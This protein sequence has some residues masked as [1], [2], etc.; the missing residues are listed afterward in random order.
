MTTTSF[1][2]IGTITGRMSGDHRPNMQNIPRSMESKILHCL[3]SHGMRTFDQ[4]ALAAGM[5]GPDG[6]D[7]PEK[8]H[9]TVDKKLRELMAC[10]KIRLVA[11]KPTLCFEVGT[12]LDRIVKEIELDGQD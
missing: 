2:H 9:D 8:F 5:L 12:V 7:N 4:L 6:F 3:S 11:R 10:G 1:A